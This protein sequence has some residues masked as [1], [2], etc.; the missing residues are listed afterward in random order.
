MVMLK[1]RGIKTWRNAKP[2]NKYVFWTGITLF[3]VFALVY[4]LLLALVIA[5]SRETPPPMRPRPAYAIV[6][7]HASPGGVA[8]DWLMERLTTAAWLYHQGHSHGLIVSGGTGPGDTTSV[9]S[10]MYTV[11]VEMGVSSEHIFIEDRAANTYENFDYSRQLLQ[12]IMSGNG[13]EHDRPFF[14]V[15][16]GFHMGRSLLT[17]YLHFGA[18]HV[19]YPVV[20]GAEPSLRLVLAYLR[21]PIS[22]MYN[23]IRYVIF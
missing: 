9:A 7:G 4:V 18:S 5:I 14:V 16:N 8:S 22:I 21:E 6:L 15:T 2:A 3:G 20:A 13:W 23:V 10:V 1:K 17:G 11:L 12:Y 19:L